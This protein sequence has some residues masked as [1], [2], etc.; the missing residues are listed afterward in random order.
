MAA[1]N[2]QAFSGDVEISSNLAV[3]GS[4]FTY[5]NTNTTVFT[6]TASGT[7]NEIGVWNIG[8]N[9]ADNTLIDVWVTGATG[10]TGNEM[11]YQVYTRPDSGT[12]TA[13]NSF[14]RNN[15]T[16]APVVYRT[17][18]TDMTGGVIRIG[19]ENSKDQFVT[20]RVKV[21]TRYQAE[22]D[23]QVTN[24]GS[25]VDGT[26]LVQV[27]PAP[28]TELNS[29]LAVAGSR[30]FV[31]TVSG[32][33]GIGTT[34]PLTPLDIVT[35]TDATNST[36]TGLT[37]QSTTSGTATD[38]FGTK[39]EFRAERGD[40]SVQT[41]CG[42][43]DVSGRN[44]DGI[45]DLWDMR[46]NVRNND[47]LDT[48]L[49]LQSQRGVRTFQGLRA[50]ST[51]NHS[52][53]RYFPGNGEYPNHT[54][55]LLYQ[56][57]RSYNTGPGI[58][59]S[60]SYSTTSA[61]MASYATIKGVAD[62]PSGNE[63]ALR[64]YVNKGA[65]SSS[66]TQVM[67]I[68]STGTVDIHKQDP[69]G[70]WTGDDPCLRLTATDDS[71]A[72]LEFD[73]NRSWVF[74][75]VST[76]QSGGL[77]LDST[78]SAKFF[79]ITNADDDCFEFYTVPDDAI[80]TTLKPYLRIPNGH[81]SLGGY[82]QQVY[83]DITGANLIVDTGSRMQIHAGSPAGASDYMWFVGTGGSG[84]I[85]ARVV[86]TLD[87]NNR[88][89]GVGTTE[90]LYDLDVN[91]N[92][93][94]QG[95]GAQIH[96]KSTFDTSLND[97]TGYGATAMKLN[98]SWTMRGLSSAR[99]YYLGIAVTSPT[100]TLTGA[101][102]WAFSGGNNPDPDPM[103]V[104]T[105]DSYVYARK[106]YQNGTALSSDDRIKNNEKRI[107]NA[108]QALLK[109][110]PQTYEKSD[111]FKDPTSN[112]YSLE[113]GLIVQDVWYDAPELRH[114]VE[115][116][117]D[118]TP[119][120]TKP[121]SSTGDIQDDP[122]YSQWGSKQAYL[123]YTGFVPYLIK[124][125]QEL[126]AEQRK[127]KTCVDDINYSNVMEYSGLIVCADT[128]T[129]KNGIPRV[130]LSQTSSDKSCFGVISG[131]T[132]T[133]DNEVFIQNYGHG[134]M[135][136]T[137]VN[138]ALESGDYITTSN[139]TGYGQKQ[140]S[141][142]LGNYTVAKITQDCDFTP[143]LI[144]TKRVVQELRDVTYY[145]TTTMIDIEEDEYNNL[146][147]E[148][149]KIVTKTKYRIKT[150]SQL[151]ELTD[152]EVELYRECEETVKSLEGL[153]DTVRSFYSPFEETFHMEIKTKLSEFNRPGSIPVT[154]QEMVNVLDEYGQLQWEDTDETEQAYEIRYLDAG[155][156]ITDEANTVHKAALVGC[157]IHCG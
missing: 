149:R 9:V 118:A 68:N 3:S 103:I 137:D 135:W 14:E 33:V 2:V 139:V 7:E 34:E 107:T 36:V 15:G 124:S 77:N 144:A 131:V 10:N 90:P 92:W 87:G 37:L 73:N 18:A 140:N 143:T 20:W 28:A 89:V 109:L 83:D 102:T 152:D 91:G 72:Y 78:V 22:G 43:I 88:F 94:L 142:F 154:K 62:S 53:D 60:G 17:N 108:K 86:M 101:L 32:R 99:T 80:S 151:S 26:G 38:G 127:T 153:S 71:P 11:H 97:L 54:L 148:R 82:P 12:S 4:K 132:D 157:T 16:V 67:K 39:M 110:S 84:T 145:Q 69:T 27:T 74:K 85:A 75:S 128:N 61:F 46:F 112:S 56:N 57:T 147:D 76:D 70:N 50:E 24:T 115:L 113:S 105:T 104:V 8:N 141:E 130:T 23:F 111:S 119:T 49:H 44:L 19:Y 6:G 116:P 59:F 40:G 150:P 5:D 123:S 48:L 120:E 30:L 93:R 31:D 98:T 35:S 121:I 114:L 63:G 41:G 29:N 64:F 65:G 58:N 51:E 134:H 100:S 95:T 156:N 25:A 47:T 1:T 21:T 42:T 81:I 133:N 96:S 122:D 55:S 79:R 129:T 66:Q 13:I 117:E 126:D 138:G 146:S 52:F 136:V 45:N 155:G 125:V 106:F